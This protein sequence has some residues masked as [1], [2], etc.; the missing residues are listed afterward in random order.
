[1]RFYA[2][3]KSVI[4]FSILNIWI[5]ISWYDWQYGASYSTRA[6]TQS[7]PVF[8]LS[9][10]ALITF[11]I[12]QKSKIIK[13]PFYA[14]SIYLIAV[15]LFQLNQ[16][17]KTILH[18]RDMNRQYYSRIYL[19]NTPNALDM[20]LLDT[21]DWLDTEGSYQ[22][23]IIT[24]KDSLVYLNAENGLTIYELK[25][26]SAISN[27]L[28]SIKLNDNYLKIETELLIN[29]GFW[30]S[31]ILTEIISDKTV[32]NS[33]QIRLFNPIVKEGENNKYA[34]YIKIPN[35]LPF[36]DLKISI[37]TNNNDFNGIL[38]HLTITHYW[39]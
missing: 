8:A 9:L 1:M 19:N 22:N 29:N 30:N 16:Y 35:D 38:N 21:H 39:K 10:G 32:V 28:K 24:T 15:N 33:N 4:W 31:Y 6:L 20:S 37:K 25:R 13:Y 12:N 2:F 34:C 26:N 27:D 17:D 11:I 18:Y 14:L 3:N 5:V 36:Y 23:E 7:Y